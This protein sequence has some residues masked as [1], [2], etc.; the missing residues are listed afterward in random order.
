MAIGLM[1]R[2]DLRTTIVKTASACVGH[3]TPEGLLV[4]ASLRE[5]DIE[6]ARARTTWALEGLAVLK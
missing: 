6:V 4:K 1:V 3:V 5:C 2:V